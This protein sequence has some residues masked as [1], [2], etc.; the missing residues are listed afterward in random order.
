MKNHWG[1]MDG[2]RESESD[3][4][5]QEEN[6]IKGFLPRRNGAGGP[7]TR[8]F[9]NTYPR[10]NGARVPLTPSIYMIFRKELS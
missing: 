5:P 2:G 10:R 4:A 3:F 8:T 9:T 6:P 1:Q 7:L